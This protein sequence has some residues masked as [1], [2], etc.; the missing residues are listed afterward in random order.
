LFLFFHS[1]A[2]IF[3]RNVPVLFRGAAPV[4]RRADSQTEAASSCNLRSISS[5]QGDIVPALRGYHTRRVPQWGGCFCAATS[6][7]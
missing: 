6:Y 7:P 2:L 3:R 4:A 5:P 1:E